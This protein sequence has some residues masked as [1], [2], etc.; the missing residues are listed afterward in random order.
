MSFECM[1]LHIVSSPRQG[2]VLL[3][4]DNTNVS[5]IRTY[6]PHHCICGD[7]STSFHIVNLILQISRVPCLPHS[8]PL[9]VTTHVPYITSSHI[10]VSRTRTQKYLPTYPLLHYTPFTIQI[11][12][13]STTPPRILAICTHVTLSNNLPLPL[14]DP[15][16]ISSP[17]LAV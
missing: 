15:H 10:R 9:K 16:V 17:L 11:V 4:V 14:Q 3:K 7:Y 1:C 2:L 12:T 6:L 8:A 5:N 13:C